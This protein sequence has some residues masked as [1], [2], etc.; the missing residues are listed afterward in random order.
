[1][2]R[3]IQKSFNHQSKFT[4]PFTSCQHFMVGA[5]VGGWGWGVK[6]EKVGE[7]KY[8]KGKIPGRRPS[9]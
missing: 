3:A 8:E 1:M 5:E 9:V 4:S 2:C 6:V 7:G